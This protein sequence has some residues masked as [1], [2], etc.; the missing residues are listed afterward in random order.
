MLP[1]DRDGTAA[2]DDW[3]QT[4]QCLGELGLAIALHTGD[5]KDLAALN[6]K[7]DAVYRSLVSVIQDRDVLHPKHLVAQASLA[8]RNR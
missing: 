3:A 7:A 5:C 1:I 4:Q 6:H 2:F 8:L